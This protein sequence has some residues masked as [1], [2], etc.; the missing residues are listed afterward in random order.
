M[1]YF[2][3]KQSTLSAFHFR[4]KET[5][6]WRFLQEMDTVIPWVRFLNIIK[7]WK[8]E[9]TKVGRNGFDPETLLRM[10]LLQQWYAMSDEETEDRIYDQYSFQMFLGVDYGDP[11]PDATTLCRFRNWLTKNK[12]QSK[13]LKEVN[14]FLEE[15][16]LLLKK[17]TIM[18][19]TTIKASSSTKNEKKERD[20]DA[21]STKKGNTWSFGYKVHTGVDAGGSKIIR[22]AKVT[23]AKVHDSSMF[24]ELLSG[25]EK[26]VL[27]DK[28]Y[29]NETRKT[30]LREEGIFCGILDRAVRGKKLSSHQQKRNKKLSSVRASVEHPFHVIKNIFGWTKTRYKGIVKNTEHFIGLCALQNIFISRKKLKLMG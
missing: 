28:G 27:G 8:K 7:K 13:L 26:I 15:K 23:T 5:R 6:T 16:G 24:D 14:L 1:Y 22:Q 10:W 9:E 3:M 30:Q 29:F 4:E 11:I 12:I 20:P 21:S 25:D 2:F 19:A 17:G 18:D